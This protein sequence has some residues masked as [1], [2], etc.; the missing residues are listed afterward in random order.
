MAASD[1]PDGALVAVRDLRV[2]FGETLALDGVNVAIH[3]GEILTV[4]GPNGAGKTTLARIILGLTRPESGSVQRR[5]GVTFGYVP[6]RFHVDPTLPITVGRFLALPANPGRT[7]V[8][9]ALTDVGVPNLLDRA[10]QHLS[11]GEFQRVMLA[12]ALLRRPDMLVLDEPLQGVDFG[13]QIALFDLIGELRDRHGFG[14][15]MVSHDLHIVMRATDRV[16]CI[17]RHVC[18]T[19]APETVSRHPEYLQLF[20]P[21]AA[22]ALAVYPHQH[23]HAHDVSGNVLAPDADGVRVEGDAAGRTRPDAHGTEA[24]AT[25]GG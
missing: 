10:L 2:R 20:G 25:E 23:D 5:R 1:P 22:R 14:V 19:G 18:C 9:R 4:I 11:G 12:R 17:N 8:A 7:A 21:D 24:P 16:L 6:Q 15:L 3:P 13:G